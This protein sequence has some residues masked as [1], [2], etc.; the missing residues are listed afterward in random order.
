MNEYIIKSGG[1]QTEPFERLKGQ[2]RETYLIGDC[3]EPRR[4]GDATREGYKI[5]SIL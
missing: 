4:V 3:V 5:G 1:L 2:V